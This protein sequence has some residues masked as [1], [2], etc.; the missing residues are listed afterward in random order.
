MLSVVFGFESKLLYLLYVGISGGLKT[1]LLTTPT[2]PHTLRLGFACCL[3][4]QYDAAE[5]QHWNTCVLFCESSE[6]LVQI[7][8]ELEGRFERE[9]TP[10]SVADGRTPCG[11]QGPATFPCFYHREL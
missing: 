4:S 1:M 11:G 10:L 6:S 3:C 8:T 5:Y 9:K 7:Q 2:Y